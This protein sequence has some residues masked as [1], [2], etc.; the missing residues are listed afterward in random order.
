VCDFLHSNG[1]NVI[2]LDSDGSIDQLIPIWLDAG[3]TGVYPLE[4]AAG[5]D[6]V[7]LRRKY[8]KRLAMF[9]GVD[10][11]ILARG[12][13]EIERHLFQDVK[14]P[15]MLMQGGY[16]PLIDHSVPPDVSLENFMYYW[17]IVK[18][19]TKD[20]LKYLDKCGEVE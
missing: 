7:A 5:E 4:V 15:W 14:L 12:R 20:P 13:A 10:K 8:G 16:T 9:G 3:V 11:R 19:V 2:L 6:V 17:N 1:I 18:A